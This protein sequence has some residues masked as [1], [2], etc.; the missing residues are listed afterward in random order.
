MITS[1]QIFIIYEPGMF[2]TFLA[3]LFTHHKSLSNNNLTDKFY[4]DENKF[5]AH[6]ASYKDFLKNFHEHRDFEK[7]SKKNN[8]ELINFF[9]PTKNQNLCIH[10]LCSY[11]FANIPFEKVFTN[12]VKIILVSKEDRLDNYAKRMFFSTSK[13]YESQYWYKNF[14]KKNLATVPN[15]FLEKIGIKEYLKYLKK[16]RELLLNDYT[17]NE[18]YDLLFDPDN[19]KNYEELTLLINIVCKKLNIENFNLPINKIKNFLDKNKEF[20]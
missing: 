20:L 11:S 9:Q 14:K 18:K 17:I 8:L 12:F 3:N 10:R 19:C 13:R 15:N 1:P 6:G 5:N 7:L 2:G 16:K 4:N